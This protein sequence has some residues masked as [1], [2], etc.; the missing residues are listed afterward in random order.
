[1]PGKNQWFDLSID[2]DKFQVLGRDQD[3]RYEPSTHGELR[4][5]LSK[6]NITN[7]TTWNIGRSVFQCKE[8]SRHYYH[9]ERFHN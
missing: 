9:R 2:F 3:G 4:V 6:G 1:M 8:K 5:S 7:S